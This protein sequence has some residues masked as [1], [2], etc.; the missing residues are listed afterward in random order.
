M[1]LYFAYNR[2]SDLLSIVCAKTKQLAVAYWQGAD[3]QYDTCRSFTELHGT[4]EELEDHP[5]GVFP[6][7]KTKTVDAYGLKP[8]SKLLIIYK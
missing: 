4:V 1:E 5:T 8:G 3:V 6:I 2:N 7:V